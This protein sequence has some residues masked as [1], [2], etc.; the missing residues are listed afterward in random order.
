MPRPAHEPGIPR[1]GLLKIS[2]AQSVCP[3]YGRPPDTPGFQRRNR[4]AQPARP[5]RHGHWRLRYVLKSEKVVLVQLSGKLRAPPAAP[6]SPI[7]I[8]T[9]AHLWMY[10]GGPVML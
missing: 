8:S 3:R 10:S 9:A 2:V 6:P 1:H 7:M 4:E 5:E